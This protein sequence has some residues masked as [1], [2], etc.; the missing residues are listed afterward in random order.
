MVSSS[1]LLSG[2]AG[3]ATVAIVIKAVDEFS[4][5]FAKVNKGML[6]AGAAV[7]A[8]GI[9]GA[10]AVGGLLKLAGQFEM[11][12][13]AFTTMLGSGERA[14]KMLADLAKFAARTPF[15]ITGVEQNAKQLMAMGI[16]TEKLLPTLKSLGDISAGLNV[17][18]ERIAL[19]FGQ[20]KV[21]GRLTGRELRDFS[22]AGIPL[23]AELAKNLNK[24]E[25]EIKDMV[26]SGDIGFEDVEKAFTTMTSEGGRFEDLMDRMSETLPGKISNIKDSFQILGREMGQVFLPIATKVADGLSVLI[27]WFERHP[28]IAK[29]A[30]IILGLSTALALIA[31]P[32]LI[33]IGLLPLLAGGIGLV[34]GVLSPWLAVILAVIAAITAIIVVIMYWKEILLGL[35][36]MM[37]FGAAL[38]TIAWY[39]IQ[40]VVMTVWNAIISMVEWGANKIVDMIN[41]LIRQALRIPGASRLFPGLKEI[42]ALDFSAAKGE[43]VDLGSKWTELMAGANTRVQALEASLGIEKEVT[44]EI[45]KQ[46]EVTEQISK[47]QQ[48]V[49]K[50]SGFVYDKHTGE[51]WN[52]KNFRQ[53][54]FKTPEAFDSAREWGG[55]TINIE[56]V[57]GIDPEEISR[58][59]SD[60]LNNKLSL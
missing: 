13:I 28:T 58:A 20:V 17:P 18:L 43:I 36:K 23:I 52:P 54:D 56:N 11:T 50:L 8:V 49:N 51:V 55:V 19:N 47:E 27:G 10:A 40:N 6:A 4:G 60:E 35:F 5:V 59:L 44:K 46:A 41:W 22:V 21:Q 38:W 48:L 34:T 45:E 31:G 29:W 37:E 12:T 26:S 16:E 1:G 2:I 7:T 42:E 30:A 15:T 53:S 25:S 33:L 24:A 3:G 39:A 9:A 32:I 57:N 14:E